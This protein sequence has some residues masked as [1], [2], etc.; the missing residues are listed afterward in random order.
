MVTQIA[1]LALVAG[2]IGAISAFIVK[3]RQASELE[4]R[5]RYRWIG[6][7][8]VVFFIAFAM[9]A[10]DVRL[11]QWAELIALPL[12][13]AAFAISITKY[14]LF[15]IDVVISRSIVFGLLAV[16]ITVVYAVVVGT[17]GSVIAGSDVVLAIAATTIVAVLFEPVRVLVQRLANRMV[18]GNRAV[19]YEVL[20]DLTRSLPN[21]EEEDG[22]LDRMA[23][24]LRAGTG[25]ERARVW[26]VDD[27]HG[28]VLAASNPAIAEAQA[29]A[30][31]DLDGVVVPIEHDGELL[32]AFTVEPSAGTPLRP[33]EL[34]L[35][36]DLAGSA[37]LVVRKLRLDTD[38][39]RAARE[40]ASSRRR[41]V[42]AQDTEL[43][44]L[45]RQLQEGAIQDIV[46]LKVA[47]ALAA[48]TAHDE[49]T[50][51]TGELLSG[52][53]GEAQGA[54][55]EIHSLATGLYPALLEA[56]GLEPAIRAMAAAAPVPVTVTGSAPRLDRD[57]EI[58]AYYT[59]TEAA[60][61]AI[62][63]AHPP[64]TIA[65]D[66]TAA[67]L[68]FTITDNGPGFDPAT[69]A[70]GS[71]LL[72]MT[73]R[74]DTIGGTLTITTTPGTPTSITGDVPTRGVRVDGPK[75]PDHQPSAAASESGPKSDFETK[76]TAPASSAGRS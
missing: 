12:L 24:Q 34:R 49:G 46:G 25:A 29:T 44:R 35:A 11:W 61:N 36:E 62:K 67:S 64:I 74:L 43:R 26:L 52:L 70:N 48:R 19:P 16:F 27:D 8:L 71:G 30:M 21:A 57:I 38:L 65:L 45:E 40:L 41:L 17:L 18:Y 55:D 10:I 58:A 50:T 37:A 51:R 39:E 20:S 13:A 66:H 4:E 72:N 1:L 22:L 76:A 6:W 69:T 68:T 54:I 2:M 59:M 14:R 15:D 47:I 56:E 5:L 32:G 53:A 9:Y 63:H 75:E 31:D 3:W 28:F 23:I 42:D 73:D 60:T 33:A 7:A